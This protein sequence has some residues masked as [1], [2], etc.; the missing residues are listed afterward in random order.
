MA[1]PPTNAEEEKTQKKR[2][3][4]L[5]R[6]LTHQALGA[7]SE[8]VI[9]ARA[10]ADHYKDLAEEAL[11]ALDAS[12]EEMEQKKWY[13]Y[14]AMAGCWCVSAAI[15]G[16]LGAATARRQSAAQLASVA[17]EMVDLRRRGAAE[18]QRA[19]RFGSAKLAKSLI[20]TLDAMDA[21]CDTTGV[22]AA[23]NA[24]SRLFGPF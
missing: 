23:Y 9:K 21:M 2:E 1:P 11:Q 13:A 20:P 12:A 18:L 15:A 3:V 8:Q 17:Q 24:R 16:P 6:T 19:E 14:A 10:D 5:T 22:L 7:I 4:K